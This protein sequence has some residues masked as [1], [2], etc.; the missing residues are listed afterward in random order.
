MLYTIGHAANYRKAIQ[1]YAAITKLPGGY[2]FK[3]IE[4][5]KREI[6]ERNKEHVWVVFGIE[7][8][9]DIDVQPCEDGWQGRLIVEVGIVDL[10]Y[11][12]AADGSAEA[13]EGGA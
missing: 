7:A 2:A 6:S 13:T 4:D 1:E 11:E 10:G 3:T 8:T 9:W 5:A 12:V